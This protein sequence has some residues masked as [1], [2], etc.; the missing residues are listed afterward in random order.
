MDAIKEAKKF[1]G[2][3]AL[4][5]ILK[6][7]QLDKKE[8]EANQSPLGKIQSNYTR[9]TMFEKIKIVRFLHEN[10]DKIL[11]NLVSEQQFRIP[12][13]S[14][15]SKM[16]I[17]KNCFSDMTTHMGQQ[18][19]ELKIEIEKSQENIEKLETTQE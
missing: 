11:E 12:L 5:V 4:A 2:H 3:K 14:I 9:D 1:R 17:M 6:R 18:V 13:N 16:L 15:D 19:K 7:A 8:Q 10:K